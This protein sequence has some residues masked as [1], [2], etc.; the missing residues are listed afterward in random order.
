MNDAVPPF[1]NPPPLP[2]HSARG[3][4]IFLA[5]LL[6]P[7]VIMALVARSE[8][9]QNVVSTAGSGASALFCGFWLARRLHIKRGILF[10]VLMGVVLAP[11]LYGVSLVLCCVGCTLG[12]GELDVR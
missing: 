5:V 6:A 11:A 2:R 8:D 9:A 7:P 4:W 10:Q 1:L 12:G 3:W